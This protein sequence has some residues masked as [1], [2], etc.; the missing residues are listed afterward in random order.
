MYT[1]TS[2]IV[3]IGEER[4]QR[5]GFKERCSRTTSNFE[6]FFDLCYR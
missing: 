4:I 5:M 2:C 6:Y 3:A 1:S